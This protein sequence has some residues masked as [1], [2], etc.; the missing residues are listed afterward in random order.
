MPTED[1]PTLRAPPWVRRC[2]TDGVEISTGGMLQFL[3]VSILVTVA[4]GADMALITRQVLA[5]GV[6]AAD[7]T[8][9]GNL[10][11]LVVHG[12]ALA[13]G[14]S[15]ILVASSLAYTALKLAGAVY[16]CVL[17]VRTVL[18]AGRQ[19]EVIQPSVG[20]DG[21]RALTAFLLGLTSTVLNPKPALFFFTF[22][23]QFLDERHAIVP[24]VAFLVALH[25]LVGVVWLTLFARIV[26]R[27]HRVLS[28]VDVRR[29]LERATGAILIAV[30]LR[31]ALERR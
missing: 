19:P 17:G 15:A 9:A 2:E 4:P 11:G 22:V 16:L 21:T 1:R 7:R 12:V 28:R 5:S 8:V 26:Q 3:A 31:V 10:T 14:L 20:R 23:P 24:Q 27:A 25:V 30:G 18:R 29:W 13:A 6:R